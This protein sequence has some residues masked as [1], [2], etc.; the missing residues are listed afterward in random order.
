M[1]NFWDKLDMIILWAYAGSVIMSAYLLSMLGVKAWA[2]NKFRWVVMVFAALLAVV[3]Y[4]FNW[5]PDATGAQY[6]VS[7]TVSVCLYDFVISKFLP[8][9]IAR[10]DQK[11]KETRTELKKKIM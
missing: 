9:D 10:M 3:F 8:T 7:W 1:E 4:L 11:G 5:E 6:F 2:G